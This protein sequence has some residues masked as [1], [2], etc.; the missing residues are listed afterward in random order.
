MFA[1]DNANYGTAANGWEGLLRPGRHFA[2][3]HLL[4][5][6]IFIMSLHSDIDLRNIV[7]TSP[8]QGHP[9]SELTL[10]FRQSKHC[11]VGRGGFSSVA[12]DG[13]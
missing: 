8:S 2:V 9:R 3:H 5:F 6:M 12:D 7:S 13:L 4:E 11:A 1:G 10:L